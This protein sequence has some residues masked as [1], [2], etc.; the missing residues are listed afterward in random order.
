MVVRSDVGHQAQTLLVRFTSRRSHRPLRTVTAL[1][2][3]TL[4]AWNLL[5]MIHAPRRCC[6]VCC[7]KPAVRSNWVASGNNRHTM[8]HSRNTDAH[9]HA[10][11]ALS[12]LGF[13]L[14]MRYMPYTLSAS[15]ACGQPAAS[16]SSPHRQALCLTH[17]EAAAPDIS[18]ALSSS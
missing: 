12:C 8:R 11:A 18:L 5:I 10:C 4:E 14:C 16:L 13:P 7:R 1:P 3:I 6:E 17:S 9:R 15:P 2:C